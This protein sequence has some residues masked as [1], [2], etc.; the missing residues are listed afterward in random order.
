[1][2][3]EYVLFDL[4]GTLLDTLPLIETSFRHAFEQLKIPWANGA[5][6][7]TIGIPLRDAC[8]QFGGDRWQELF[9]CYVSYQLTIHD[10]HVKVFPG[11]MEALADISPLV[12]GMAIV[13]SKRR[14]VAQRGLSVTGLGRYMQHLVALEDVE[15]PKPNPEPV[16]CGLE[17]FNASPEQAIFIGDS[18]FDI[19]SGRQA[20]VVTVAVSWGMAG[21][22]DLRDSKPD[23]LVDNWPDLVALIKSI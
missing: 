1:M 12:R 16:L 19:M 4:D 2:P 3:K 22:E 18:C 14:P 5:V 17:K 9:D 20:G 21:P 10:A 8:K 6:M 15:K 23:F 7:K 11:T 13:T